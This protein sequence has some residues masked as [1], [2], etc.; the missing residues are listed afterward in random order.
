[1]IHE[2]IVTTINKDKKVHKGIKS[3]PILRTNLKRDESEEV[4]FE[5]K[6]ETT[7]APR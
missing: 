7:N 1:M 5:K 4:K 6:T 3:T 2:V